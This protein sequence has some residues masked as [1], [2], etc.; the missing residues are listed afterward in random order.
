MCAYHLDVVVVIEYHQ[1]VDVVKV[2]PCDRAMAV[3]MPKE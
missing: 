1:D 2:R 3:T